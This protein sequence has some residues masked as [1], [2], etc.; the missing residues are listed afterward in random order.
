MDNQEQ[1]FFGSVIQ[2]IGTVVSAI[3][4]TPN[5]ILSEETWDD[6]DVIGNVLQ[7]TGNAL[8]AN[9]QQVFTMSRIGNEVQ[10]IGNTTV[11][12]G[13]VI[14]F[15][16]TTKQT[17]VIKGNLL[18]AV[19]AGIEAGDELDEENEPSSNS[20]QSINIIANLLQAAGNSLQAFGGIY[21]LQNPNGDKDYSESLTFA[22]SWIQAIGAV[23]SALESSKVKT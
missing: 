1:Q 15:D 7:A 23:L 11:I 5:Q 20:N 8:V 14:C 21:D 4:N 16:D 18:Q 9:G 6:I 10:A 3:A 2:A 12:A 19:G 17:L 22:G 13:M